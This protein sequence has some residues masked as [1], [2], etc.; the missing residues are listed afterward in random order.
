[1]N[2][3]TST[4]WQRTALF[5]F[6]SLMALTIL[7]S[8]AAVQSTGTWQSAGALDTGDAPMIRIIE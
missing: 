3:G 4:A 6:G 2:S 5:L 7:A 8:T 1:M